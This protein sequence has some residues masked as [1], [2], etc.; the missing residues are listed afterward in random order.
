MG[1][2]SA[3]FQ[4]GTDSECTRKRFRLGSAYERNRELL[5]PIGMNEPAKQARISESNEGTAYDERGMYSP[6]S[7]SVV[8][9]T[10]IEQ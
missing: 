2:S 9:D 8:G 6:G 10:R 1:V 5:P 7:P 3:V 4:L